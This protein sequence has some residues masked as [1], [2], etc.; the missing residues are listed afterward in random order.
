MHTKTPAATFQERQGLDP[1]GPP[2]QGS[3]ASRPGVGRRGEVCGDDVGRCRERFDEGSKRCSSKQTI[4]SGLFLMPRIYKQSWHSSLSASF[5]SSSQ[6]FC[7]PQVLT[8][9]PAAHCRK[10]HDPGLVHACFPEDRL[11]FAIHQWNKHI[12]CE[13]DHE[14]VGIK[15]QSDRIL[16]TPSNDGGETTQPNR[17]SYSPSC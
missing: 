8:T 17:I 15:L 6:M 11:D 1:F 14:A 3:S 13:V 2:P 7:N 9:P 16:C 5:F 4:V 12:L 10:K